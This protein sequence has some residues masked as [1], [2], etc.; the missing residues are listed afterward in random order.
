MITRSSECDEWKMN[1]KVGRRLTINISTYL[2]DK[3]TKQKSL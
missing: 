2:G 3:R 1:D